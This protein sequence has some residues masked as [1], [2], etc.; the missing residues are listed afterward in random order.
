M[1]GSATKTVVPLELGVGRVE[2]WIVQIRPQHAV[3]QIVEHDQGG[4][5]PK[6]LQGADMT[7]QPGRVVLP[8]HKTHEAMA[9]V[10]EDQD[11][12]P[13]SAQL[14]ALRIPHQSG[15]P[16]INLSLLPSWRVQAHGHR[17]LQWLDVAAYVTM[18]AHVADSQLVILLKQPLHLS[19]RHVRLT[20]PI[21]NLL[22]VGPDPLP[23]G[24]LKDRRVHHRRDQ[25]RQLVLLGQR[26]FPT[27]SLLRQPAQVLTDRLAGHPQRVSNLPHAPSSVPLVD[28]L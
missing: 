16:K 3:F 9:T 25:L 10:A 14:A 27:Q 21:Y 17:P 8:K 1:A 15:I 2:G 26:P 13:G 24:L 18:Y 19:N 7:V 4:A 28:H 23:R 22:V 5:T 12:G 6:E 20:Q 11:K